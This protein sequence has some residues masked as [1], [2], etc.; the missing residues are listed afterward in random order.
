VA[1]HHHDGVASWAS[2]ILTGVQRV[3][4][5]FLVIRHGKFLF[6]RR[7]YPERPDCWHVYYGDVSVGTIA[8]RTGG[9]FRVALRSK[10][11]DLSVS[12][13]P[14]INIGLTGEPRHVSKFRT[15]TMGFNLP[16]IISDPL[17]GKDDTG[18]LFHP[19]NMRWEAADC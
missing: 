13:Q 10:P 8:R 5:E 11:G 2:G 3:E 9:S 12:R 15:G 19:T 18:R 17:R 14:L 1:R 4:Q 6:I 16:I 7:L